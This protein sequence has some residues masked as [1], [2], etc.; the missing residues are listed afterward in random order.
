MYDY[1]VILFKYNISTNAELSLD[2][3][4][5]LVEIDSSF[6]IILS[7]D[8]I[9]LS[10]FHHNKKIDSQIEDIILKHSKLE[11][12]SPILYEFMF[13]ITNIFI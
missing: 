2:Y 12:F 9:E 13:N 4:T 3:L 8:I 11:E 7:N 6:L 5:K 1:Y 10:V